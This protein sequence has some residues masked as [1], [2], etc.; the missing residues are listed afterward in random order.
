MSESTRAARVIRGWEHGFSGGPRVVLSAL[1]GGYRGLLGAREWLYGHHVL[2][3]QRLGCPV[4]SI[5]NLTV[6]GTGKTPAVELAAQT[7]SALGRR[8]AIV[9]RGYRRQSNGIQIVADTASLR[10]DPAE[11][12]DEPFLLARRLPGVAVVVGANRYEAARL[13]VERFG[14]TAIVLDDGF[15]HRTLA[16]DVEIVMIRARNP[17][18]NGQLLP[19][20]PLREPLSALARAALVVAA[21]A[22]QEGDL[23]E[24]HAAV[25]RHAPDVP[26]VA[27][28]YVPV[29]C[30]EASRL[31]PE[32]PQ[33]L[34]GRRLVAFA[35]LASPEGFSRTLETMRVDVA[36][37]ETF[38]DH[39]WYS[40]ADL[41][42][43]DRRAAALGADGLVTTEKDWVRLRDVARP[44]R[45]IHV[46]SVRLELLEGV[47]RWQ[48]VFERAC[49]KP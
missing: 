37:F 16:K 24:I 10:L 8:V 15:Q 48:R 2:R 29:E 49:T 22:E 17:W 31:R 11:A 12:G 18:G 30:W 7:L 1:A 9:S 6:G 20:G 46:V 32:A 35:G 14:A 40:P 47:D 41:A 42:A 5:G 28:R 39:H 13:A 26:V 44:R 36:H 27:A 3:S 45:P 19:H 21:G 38:V 23:A 43:L 4:V 34:A 25:G 33:T